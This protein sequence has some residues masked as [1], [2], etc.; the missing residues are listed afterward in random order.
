VY[1]LSDEL[2][3]AD[4]ELKKAKE[5]IS[6]VSNEALEKIVSTDWSVEKKA[7]MLSFVASAMKSNN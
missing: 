2:H 4:E 7:E 6:L 3:H 1:G 5:I